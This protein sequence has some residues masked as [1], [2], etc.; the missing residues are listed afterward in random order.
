MLANESRAVEPYK[1]PLPA[2]LLQKVLHSLPFFPAL[3]PHLREG[4][5]PKGVR[6]ED[7][8]S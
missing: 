5:L 6:F 2:G 3:L 4:L 8:A 1:A 7:A